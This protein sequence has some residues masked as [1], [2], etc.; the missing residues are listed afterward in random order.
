MGIIHPIEELDGGWQL[1]REGKSPVCESHGSG[2]FVVEFFFRRDQCCSGFVHDRDQPFW[3]S[4]D[5]GWFFVHS[6]LCVQLGSRDKPHGGGE[7]AAERG[8]RGSI[9]LFVMG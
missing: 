8:L 3:T 1:Q 7:F 5:G 4:G 2:F 9:S 6:T